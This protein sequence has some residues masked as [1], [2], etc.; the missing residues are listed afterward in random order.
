MDYLYIY[1]FF[2]NNIDLIYATLQTRHHQVEN[3]EAAP[4]VGGQ[5]MGV[6]VESANQLSTV[7]YRM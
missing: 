5:R 6:P 4:P 7:N 1:I 3:Q 2:N